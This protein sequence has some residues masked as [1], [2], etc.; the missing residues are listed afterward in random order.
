MDAKQTF[1]STI[2]DSSIESDT[3]PLGCFA[4]TVSCS[5]SN[6]LLGGDSRQGSD[7]F[8][9]RD[10][11]P[12]RIDN[13]FSYLDYNDL[14]SYCYNQLGYSTCES[15]ANQQWFGGQSSNDTDVCDTSLEGGVMLMKDE[16]LIKV[17]MA[18]MPLD[19]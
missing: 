6:Y 18:E 11:V 10:E 1:S 19:Q 4:D 15:W 7:G 3:N 12:F 2:S 16:L 13:H 9:Y 5:D 17:T 8:S 14:K